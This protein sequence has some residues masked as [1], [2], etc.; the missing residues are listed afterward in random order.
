MSEEKRGRGRPRVAPVTIFALR[1]PLAM[2]AK[3]AELAEHEDR[4]MAKW[5]LRELEPL[6][7]AAHARLVANAKRRTKS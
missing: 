6:V 5:M 1:M 3:I 2:H 7:D 4:S